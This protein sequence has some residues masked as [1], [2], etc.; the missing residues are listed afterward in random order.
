MQTAEPWRLL[1]LTPSIRLLGARQSLLS[2]VQNLPSHISPHVVCSGGGALAVALREAQIPVS[3]IPHYPWRKF[4]GRLNA[5]IWQLPAL[6]AV[7]RQFKP[8][9]IHC[10]EYH[11]TPQGI[12]AA[13]ATQ[14]HALVT[15]HLRNAPSQRHIRNYEVGKA[16][17]I[18]T[19]SESIRP[20]L[21]QQNLEHLVRVVHNGID[22]EK[23]LTAT[24]TSELRN[25]LGWPQTDF[26]VGLLGLV[27]PRKAQLVLAEA[28]ALARKQGAPVRLLLAGDAF[29]SSLEYGDALRVRLAQPD[30]AGAVHW[31]PFQKDILS[32]Y[33]SMNV[34]ALISTEEGFGRT[35]I[36]AGALGIPSV[37]SRIGGI[38]EIILPEKTGF[39]IDEGNSQALAEILIHASRQPEVIQQ[40]G[41]AARRRVISEFSL[42][43]TIQKLVAIWEELI[44]IQ[45]TK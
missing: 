26:V 9:V 41:Q 44:A 19:V 20:L 31:V 1:L 14:P 15:T 8:H 39:L 42:I 40:L 24:P 37:G 38:P 4:T 5:A 35:I 11:S 7:V 25:N 29:K 45:T 22:L 33:G 18:I 34:N 21:R 6:R 17:A 3:I 28:V 36:E 30:L 13:K 27:S 23:F 12:R 32:L 2:L 16:E 10:N 43:A